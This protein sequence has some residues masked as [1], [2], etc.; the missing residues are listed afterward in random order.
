[1]WNYKLSIKLYKEIYFKT[2]SVE[3]DLIQCLTQLKVNI[4]KI[5]SFCLFLY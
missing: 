1:M 2:N 5:N 3:R 4:G